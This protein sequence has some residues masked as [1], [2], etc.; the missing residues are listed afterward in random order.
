MG[1]WDSDGQFFPYYVLVSD[2]ARALKPVLWEPWSNGGEPLLIDPQTGILSP[3]TQLFGLIFGGSSR[4]FILYWLFMWWLGGAGMLSLARHLK[5]PVWAGFICALGLLFCGIYTGNAE[6]LSWIISFSFIPWILWRLD[7]SLASSQRWPAVEAGALLG[8]SALAG[9]PGFTTVTGFFTVLWA[10]GRALQEGSAGVRVRAASLS[11]VIQSAVALVVFSP[12][13]FGFF[14]EGLGYH[15]R[16]G[17]LS[18]DWAVSVNALDPGAIAT[19]G[20]PYLPLLK[21]SAPALW[22][23][24]DISSCS[25]YAGGSVTVLALLA[26][27]GRNRGFRWWL[28]AIAVLSICL[29]VGNF[30]PLRGWLYDFVIPTRYFRHSSLFRAYYIF[31][32]CILALKGARDLDRESSMAD[33]P[34]WKKLPWIAAACALGAGLA[35]VLTTWSVGRTVRSFHPPL[36]WAH[37]GVVWGGLAIIGLIAVFV[38][39]LARMNWVIP[40]FIVI[41]SCDAI[42]TRFIS[43]P[44]IQAEDWKSV[45]RWRL[46]DRQHNASVSPVSYRRE[47]QL[48]IEDTCGKNDQLIEKVPV[49]SAYS[50][51]ENWFHTQT[52]ASNA[53]RPMALG[54]QRSWFAA[55]APQYP[56]T[57][58][59]FLMLEREARAAGRPPIVIHAPGALLQSAPATWENTSDSEGCAA[60]AQAP[61][62]AMAASIV[63]TRSETAL[64]DLVFDAPSDGWLLL[65]DRWARSW[66]VTINSRPEPLWCANFIFRGV[67]VKK[68]E[69]KIEFGYSPD[70]TVFLAA[71]S[72][73]TLAAIGI[74]TLRYSFFKR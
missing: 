70:V 8:L 26:V 29:A 53:L 72:W 14:Y 31:S 4:A 52:L 10:L 61:G 48:C 59:C 45:A 12:V 40:A 42:L 5:A 63:I 9:Y 28:A 13:L 69:N 23:D 64:L 46:L 7:V 71:L 60:L 74:G 20:S 15:S 38:S 36:E 62:T 17:A 21:F 54:E 41:A 44:T 1:I 11:I 24:N 37:F 27:F 39:P 49:L 56:W 43:S 47:E 50:T 18:R 34:A 19:F 35:I 58:G 16:V 32:A 67:Q 57:K 66:H 55:Q 68:G 22:R 33:S 73:C 65:T 2:S 25:I 3:L 6:H 51:Q 30:L